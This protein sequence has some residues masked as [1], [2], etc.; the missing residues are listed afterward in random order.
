MARGG[1]GGSGAGGIG[2][3]AGTATGGIGGSGPG[4]RGGIGGTAT[5]GIGGSGAG[6]IDGGAGMATAGMGGFGAGGT[7]GAGGCTSFQCTCGSHPPIVIDETVIIQ[8]SSPAATPD[9]WNACL[10]GNC[11]E[12]CAE[13]EPP[14]PGTLAS[15]TCDRLNSDGGPYDGGVDEDAGSGDA[16]KADAGGP[17]LLNFVGTGHVDCTGRRPAGLERVRLCACG[18][19]AGRWFARAAAL[20][21]ASVPAFRHLARELAA[22]G[23]PPHLVVAAR[24]AVAEEARHYALMAR[25]ARARGAEPRR[26]RVRPM[27]V[28]PLV[29]V[30]RENARE[31]CVRETFGAM[32]ASFQS[33][34]ASDAELR[35]LMTSIAREEAGHA[36]LAWEIDYWAR[37]ALPPADARAVDEARRTAG[38]TLVAELGRAEPPAALART[39]G[40]PSPSAERRHARWIQRALWAA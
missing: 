9:A 27:R 22:H 18:S 40:L 34:H 15:L 20:E 36:R 31:G 12:L 38:A 23:A 2:G 37:R 29:E 26:P 13:V 5:G 3:G 11:A 19:P 35:A 7:G 10:A 39:L 6:G 30:A 1:I 25:A 21:A 24:A 33:R 8:P 4:G 17:I 16:Q 32:T 14:T 28:R